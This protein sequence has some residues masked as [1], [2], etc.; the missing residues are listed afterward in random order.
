MVF[1]LEI[2]ISAVDERKLTKILYFS[3]LIV[4]M[5]RIFPFFILLTL[6]SCDYFNVKKTTSE[7]ILKEELK[8]FSWNEVDVYP[9]FSSC[10]STLIKEEK[11]V[12]FESTLSSYIMES[13]QQEII[14]V[15][16]DLK[17]TIVIAF[18]ISEEGLL[19][20][21][22]I[23]VNELTELEIPNI[24]TKIEES[25]DRLPKIY[26]AIKRGQQVKTAFKLPLEV[27]VN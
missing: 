23:K 22:D 4:F 24:R 12:C 2:G 26:P 1:I 16:Q 21:T 25:L 3:A 6:I 13:L 11:K 15:T 17:D 20:L 27:R 14:V 19:N 18:E 10:D 9:T 8:T 7:A 5:K